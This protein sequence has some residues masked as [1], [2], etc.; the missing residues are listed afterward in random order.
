M[1]R[2][3]RLCELAHAVLCAFGGSACANPSGPSVAS[4]QANIAGSGKTLSITN[5]P[6]TIIN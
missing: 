6:G 2:P 1:P 3:P 4:G 5:T